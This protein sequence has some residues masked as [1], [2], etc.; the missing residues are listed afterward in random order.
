MNSAALARLGEFVKE[1]H[2]TAAIFSNPATITWLSG[3][4]PQI[5]T[6]P[7]PFE[8]GPAL[9]WWLDDRMTLVLSDMESTAA[10]A[11]ELDTRDYT[12]Y[13]ID[14]PMSGFL[15]Q[16]AALKELLSSFGS[17]KG[18]IG[19]ELNFL[20]AVMLE[21]IKETLPL[22]ELTP[23]DGGFDFLRAIKSPEEIKTIRA[24]LKICDLAQAETKRLLQPGVSEI[25]V[26]GKLKGYLEVNAGGRLPLLADFI[27]GARTAEIGG[28]PGENILGSGDPVIADIVPRVNGYWG[29]NAGTHFVG[30]PAPELQ[31]VYQIV[32]ATLRK[33]ITAI[34]PGLRAC[35]LD[36]MLRS[37]IQ[38]QGYPRYP[39]HSGHGLG[40]SYHEEP[41][42]VP[43]NTMKLQPGMVIAIEPGI[44]LPGLG[45]VRLEDVVLVSNNGCEVLTHHLGN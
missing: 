43:Y 6:G 23:L 26:W 22:V 13:S 31:R 16:A 20:P 7:N 30:E 38:G 21:V 18:N 1:K 12:A 14:A 32:L 15:N 35:D 19:V 5:Q 37:A 25:E 42:I 41:R 40:T 9:G 29:D 2:L 3:Y 10:R 33:G 28:L 34:K 11:Q 45:G 44:Y 4:A 8:G 39:H 27:G 36:N 24:A 17:L